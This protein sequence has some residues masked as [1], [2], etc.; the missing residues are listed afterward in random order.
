MQNSGNQPF[1]SIGIP[2]YR[3]ME[4]IRQALESCLKQNYENY[5]IL[6][7]DDT[8]DDSIQSIVESYRSEKL[9]YIHNK[10]PLGLVSKL[11][12][13]LEKAK[14]EWMLI[15]C[16]D[17]NLE[18]DYLK[19]LSQHITAYPQATLI[20]CQY[21]LINGEGKQIRLDRAN[22]FRMAPFEFLRDIFLPEDQSFKMNISGILFQ[23]SL[24]KTL[25]GFKNLHR[26]WHVDRLAWAELGARGESICEPRALCNV[27]LHEV[28][29]T[30]GVEPNYKIAVAA[31]LEMK[32][33][34]E[35]LFEGILAK[36]KTPEDQENLKKARQNFHAY[37][38]RHLSKSLDQGLIAALQNKEKNAV[39]EVAKI[40]Q[41]MK[42]LGVP[43]FRSV[44]FYRFLAPFPYSFRISLLTR[45]QRYKTKKWTQ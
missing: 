14:A 30:A 6:V 12:D 44:I 36:A 11:N 5:E 26:G 32:K 37:I 27:R 33:I 41:Y 2:T 17:D 13:F 21:R 35:K 42:E 28:S 23:K 22:S 1:I 10:S 43:L 34:V 3:R 9:R 16:D 31:D 29:I 4:F 39:E 18:P 45:L 15:L 19:A 24:L 40:S 20:R 8:E 38:N 7:N 25:G